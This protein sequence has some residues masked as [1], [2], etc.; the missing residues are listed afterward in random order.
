[1]VQP[2]PGKKPY[3]FTSKGPSDV[4]E[5]EF[6]SLDDAEEF[7]NKLELEDEDDN[8]NE[9]IEKTLDLFKRFKSFN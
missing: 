8:I 7:V 3:D 4:F 2:N 1:M 6:I 9:S 5:D